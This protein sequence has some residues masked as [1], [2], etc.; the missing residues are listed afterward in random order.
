MTLLASLLVTFLVAQNPA[1]DTRAP[2][3]APASTVSGR[4]LT[5]AGEPIR[6]ARV[7]LAAEGHDEGWPVFTDA[8]GRFRFSKLTAGRYILTASKAGYVTTRFGARQP[9][10]PP[11]AIE[12]APGTVLDN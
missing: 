1:R 8:Y 6:K 10:E 2:A 3:A 4:I 11:V 7:G 12:V 9:L 5:D